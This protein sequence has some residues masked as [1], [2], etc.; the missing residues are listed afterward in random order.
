MAAGLSTLMNVRL[1]G[2]STRRSQTGSLAKLIQK[3]FEAF[4]SKRKVW[5]QRNPKSG[6]KKIIEVSQTLK[7]RALGIN[8]R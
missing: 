7:V 1:K 3:H 8:L 4:S 2:R 5:R 6:Q